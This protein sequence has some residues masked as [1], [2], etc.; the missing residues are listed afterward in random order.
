MKNF[1]K[2]LIEEESK[3]KTP[4]Q[5]SQRADTRAEAQRRVDITRDLMGLP[6]RNQ[7]RG[8]RE[9]QQW[10]LDY[11]RMKKQVEGEREERHPISAMTR[12]PIKQIAKMSE[13]FEKSY[14][15]TLNNALGAVGL[16]TVSNIGPISNVPSMVKSSLEANPTHS[17]PYF[18]NMLGSDETS[19]MALP[20]GAQDTNPQKFTFLSPPSNKTQQ[21]S[22]ESTPEEL[23]WG[24]MATST[25]L[26]REFFDGN[27]LTADQALLVGGIFH[28]PSDPMRR[29]N[30]EKTWNTDLG[31]AYDVEPGSR[32]V[33]ANPEGFKAV[34]QREKEGRSLPTWF[35]Q[36]TLNQASRNFWDAIQG[37]R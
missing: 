32:E 31:L 35:P 16:P 36:K 33:Y 15:K 29:F 28:T 8:S 12:E 9:A 25:Q 26:G 10:L 2:F 5:L 23:N 13:K 14:K 20:S 19:Y 4:R 11:N 24:K 3:R 21:K 27:N 22:S 37:N 6:K 1:T 30:A 7:T 18:W 34:R 17:Q